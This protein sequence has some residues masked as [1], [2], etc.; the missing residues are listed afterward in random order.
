MSGSSWP[1]EHSCDV[2]PTVA[3][4]SWNPLWEEEVS[5]LSEGLIA[6]RQ[7]LEFFIPLSALLM[8][9]SRL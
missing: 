1:L 5:E 2:C 6:L 7:V 9:A 3:E 4:T 8:A